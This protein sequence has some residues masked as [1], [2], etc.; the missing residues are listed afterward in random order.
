MASMSKRA[1][2]EQLTD[3]AA[4]VR[5]AVVPLARQLRQ[6][7]DDGVTPTQL[8]VIGTIDRHGP[9]SLGD[10]AALERLS[11]PM[12]TKV[13]TAL[14]GLGLI[15]RQPDEHDRRV[16]RVLLTAAGNRWLH[17]FRARRDA[18]LSERLTGLDAGERK[19]LSDA[20]PLL[21]RLLRDRPE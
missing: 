14:E 11:P 21:E 19:L 5:L 17:G 3:L 16:S 13:V 7:V 6:Q 18:W 12:I 2:E 10:L 9:I 8:S 4:R 20:L 1:S 15:E